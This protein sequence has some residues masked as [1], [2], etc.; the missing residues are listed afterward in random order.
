MGV[1]GGRESRYKLPGPGRLEGG[2]GL[3]TLHIVVRLFV[4][5]TR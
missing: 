1:R 3:T 5:C 2:P 4:D